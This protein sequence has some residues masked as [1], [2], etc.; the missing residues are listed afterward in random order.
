MTIVSSEL[1]KL[2]SI[3]STWVYLALITAMG[4]AAAIT[5]SLNYQTWDEV[6]AVGW[7]EL[8]IGAD[9]ALLIMIFAAAGI[10]GTDLSHKTITWSYLANN[11]RRM[12]LAAQVS[13]VAL[14]VVLSAL[15][16]VLIAAMVNLGLGIRMDLGFNAQSLAPLSS[17]LVQWVVFSLLSAL[18]AVILRSGMFGAMIMLAD[19]FVIEV[20]LGI[21]GIAWLEP[22]LNLLPLANS[23]VLGLGEFGSVDHGRLGAAV[24]LGLTIAVLGAIAAAGVQRRAVR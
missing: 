21:A 4:A 5:Q 6:P 19:F 15:L 17:A 12:H 8:L 24:I 16:G 3:R 18:C 2:F 23:R 20:M 9:F 14:A 13:L 10:I 1:I 7:N 11:H 22:V